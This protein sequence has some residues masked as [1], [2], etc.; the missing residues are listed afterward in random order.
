M[1]VQSVLSLCEQGES[2]KR[3]ARRVKISEPKVT[4]ILV[5]NGRYH[6]PTADIVRKD[7]QN[8][9]TVQQICE[10]RGM[11]E[12]TIDKYIPYRKGMYGAKYAPKNALH[13]KAWRE[14]KKANGE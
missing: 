3:I 14:K 10:K 8:G 12:K 6:S 11:S 9:M 1:I 7:L 5:T 4:K 2:V 13:I